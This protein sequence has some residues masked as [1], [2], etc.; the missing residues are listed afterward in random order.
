VVVKDH[1]HSSSD[2]QKVVSSTIYSLSG[3]G[4]GQSLDN[5]SMDNGIHKVNRNY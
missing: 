4:Y 5:S 2:V 1:L 3:A